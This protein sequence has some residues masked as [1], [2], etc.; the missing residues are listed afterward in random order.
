[1][2]KYLVP[3]LVIITLWAVTIAT[4]QAPPQPTQQSN[5][6]KPLTD[7]QLDLLQC[8]ANVRS[9]NVTVE[10]MRRQHEKDLTES[11]GL[12]AQIKA[13]EAR[14]KSLEAGKNTN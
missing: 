12:K 8:D 7:E 13:Q 3:M 14:I 9:L 4:P 11:D 1:M 10:K 2:R 5:Q 6:P